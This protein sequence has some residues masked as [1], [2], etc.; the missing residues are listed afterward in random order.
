MASCNNIPKSAGASIGMVSDTLNIGKDAQFLVK[1]AE[2]NLEEIQLGKLAQQMGTTMDLK[3]LGEM[4]ENDHTKSLNE[5]TTLALKKSITLPT[6]LD[7]NA[8][9][10]STKLSKLSGNEFDT[11]YCDMMVSGHKIAIALFEKEST[12]ASDPAIRQ[13]AITTLPILKKHLE[14]ATECQ[15]ECKKM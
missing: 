5:L 1:F 6:S 3:E 9:N 12:D 4:M 15:K 2:I 11:H 13:M 8:Q 14:Q 7:S 10:D